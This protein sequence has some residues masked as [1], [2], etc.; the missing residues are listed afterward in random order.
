MSEEKSLYFIKIN[1]IRL[2]FKK[3]KKSFDR[4]NLLNNIKEEP[5][6]LL[7]KMEI[8]QINNLW[9]GS[10]GFKNQYKE[11]NISSFSVVQRRIIA[12][13]CITSR[14]GNAFFY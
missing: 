14:R 9:I 12:T 11:F 13:G 6:H 4:P 1:F 3:L 7:K 8:A 5:S 2:L 10:S